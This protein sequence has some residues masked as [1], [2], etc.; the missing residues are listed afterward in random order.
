MDKGKFQIDLETPKENAITID[1]VFYLPYFLDNLNPGNSGANGCVL[2]L[3]DLEKYNDIRD[4]PLIPDLV[5]K[6]CKHSI[7]KWKEES[8]RSKRFE[9]EIEALVDC[10]EHNL[11]NLMT[12]HH[13][14][15][16]SIRW[17][18]IER[19]RNANFRFYTMDYA[20]SQLS[21]Y[22]EVNNLSLLERLELCI[23]ICESLK[24][25]WSRNYYHRDIKPDNILFIEDKWMISDLGLA[26]HRDQ[27]IEIDDDGEWIGP[28]G[29]MS[30][31]AMNKFLAESKPWNSLHNCKINHQSDIYQIGKV[32][33]YILQGN[34]PEGGIRRSDFLWKNE[35]IYQIIRTMLNNSK[36]RRVKSIEEVISALKK[37]Q[38]QLFKV[39][40]IDMLY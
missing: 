33:W 16:A 38:K 24:Q 21:K 12:V 13:Y 39:G 28:R 22:L 29:W 20:D 40:V 14:G 32:L 25:I 9:I 23:E 3:I 17:S 37:E 10:N 15:Q 4:Y 35:N 30:P 31:E 11:P 18:D 8:Q 19:N 36:E 2:K 27:T 26:E 7:P 1:G 6:V 34:S 5:I